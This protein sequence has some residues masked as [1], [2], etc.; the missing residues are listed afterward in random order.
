L[1]HDPGH[2]VYAARELKAILQSVSDLIEIDLAAV[3]SESEGSDGR[4]IQWSP[5][6]LA[7]I[8]RLTS[9]V[10]ALLACVAFILALN[11]LLFG[12]MVWKMTK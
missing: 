11:G 3:G 5:E 8:R 7:Q 1:L 9:T 12:A 4:L 2:A 6:S 10:W